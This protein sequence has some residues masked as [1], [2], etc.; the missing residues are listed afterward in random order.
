V[1][2]LVALLHVQGTQA[3]LRD[4]GAPL[5]LAWQSAMLCQQAAD[6][7]DD[8]RTNAVATFGT[9]HGLLAAG[10]FDLARA[11]LEPALSA[12]STATVEDMQLTGML[13]FTRSLLA[14]A[15]GNGDD[16]TAP[17]TVAAELA[18]RTGGSQR[19]LVRVRTHQRRR[20]AN[21]RGARSRRLRPSRRRRRAT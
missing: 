17:L 15:D 19:L 20:L 13:A 5:D 2:R 7:L 11:Q 14:T 3:W 21:G 8:P 4:I 10:A 16:V 1:L 9:A 12:A 6:Q 18:Q